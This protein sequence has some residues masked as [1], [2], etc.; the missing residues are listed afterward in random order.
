M[1][2]RT[3]RLP[4]KSSTNSH[5][6]IPR[7][8]TR[9]TTEI[10]IVPDFMTGSQT[11]VF[12]TAITIIHRFPGRNIPIGRATASIPGGRH[13]HTFSPTRE[14]DSPREDPLSP[15]PDPQLLSIPARETN[16]PQE[17]PSYP[18]RGPQMT[19]LPARGTNFPRG[20]LPLHF[21]GSPTALSPAWK[22]PLPEQEF[23]SPIPGPRML[24]F[25]RRYRSPGL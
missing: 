7:M 3:K 23:P 15:I 16:L 9:S 21:R 22:N 24:P 18:I 17:D 14:A 20:V 1:G 6:K 19:S 25:P 12:L 10:P 2:S 5:G 11:S 8:R 4:S 13:S